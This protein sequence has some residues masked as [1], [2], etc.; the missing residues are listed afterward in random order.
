MTSNPFNIG[1]GSGISGPSGG[2][3]PITPGSGNLTDSATGEEYIARALL[4]ETAGLA[5]I[6]DPEGNTRTGVPLAAGWNPQGAI[7]VT[8]FA[9]T[10][11]WGI[12]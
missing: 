1:G 7:K 6:V 2:I 8:A 9:G 5:T 10:N 11:L 4:C 12:K 3:A